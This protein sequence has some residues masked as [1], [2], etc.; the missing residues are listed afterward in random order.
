MSEHDEQATLNSWVERNKH[1][2]QG[3]EFFFAIPNGGFRHITT[4]R[5]LKREGVKAGIPDTF[6][7]F[8]RGN[9]AGFFIEMKFGKGKLSPA[10][11]EWFIK[12]KSASYRCEV[13]YSFEEAR[14]L[15]LEYLGYV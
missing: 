12:F 1:K 5:K 6:L 9:Y 11:R 13:C 3:L 8:P 7:A 10:Q 14:T 15:L 4:A 2:Y